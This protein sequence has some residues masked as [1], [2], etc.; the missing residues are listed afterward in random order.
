MEQYLQVVSL[1][2]AEPELRY[3]F[4]RDS[5]PWGIRWSYDSSKLALDIRGRQERTVA[6]LNAETGD[7]DCEASL[8]DTRSLLVGNPAWDEGGDAI[9]VPGTEAN[10]RMDTTTGAIRR[11][12]GV[13]AGE[14]LGEARTPPGLVPSPDGKLWAYARQSADLA[15][16]EVVCLAEAGGSRII[17]TGDRHM[18]WTTPSTLLTVRR[19][20][21]DQPGVLMELNAETSGERE[22][23]SDVESWALAPGSSTVVVIQRRGTAS[24]LGTLSLDDGH[25]TLRRIPGESP[26]AEP[27]RD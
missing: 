24:E 18:Q 12:D 20:A 11:V 21:P 10:Y 17:G 5:M 2:S 22:L 4:A 1:P 19:S 27:L 8:P 7:A 3:P 15:P 9:Y 25:F 14:S 26:P 6:V 23:L 16:D 13:P